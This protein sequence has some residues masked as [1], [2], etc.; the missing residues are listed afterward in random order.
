M[1][2]RE[3][4][5]VK[6]TQMKRRR[7]SRVDAFARE[8]QKITPALVARAG[9]RCELA[10]ESCDGPFHRHHRKLRGQGGDNQID[11][12][13]LVCDHHHRFIHANPALSYEAG[14][15]IRGTATT[16]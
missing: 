3:G 6:R 16:D 12:L 11:N 4:A 2:A 9:G 14:Y 15:L 5:G 8:L 1:L 7:S 13:L 10:D